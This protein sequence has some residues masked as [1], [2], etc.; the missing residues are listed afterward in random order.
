MATGNG[1]N[2]FHKNRTELLMS[3]DQGPEE[4]WWGLAVLGC[5]WGLAWDH[6]ASLTL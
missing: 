4:C 2:R 5:G 1:R 6:P 3:P